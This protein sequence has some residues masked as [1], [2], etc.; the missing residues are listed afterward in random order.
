MQHMISANHGLPHNKTLQK[1]CAIKSPAAPAASGIH[2]EKDVAG[3]PAAAKIDQGQP[4]EQTMMKYKCPD[5][6]VSFAKWGICRQHMISANHGLPH[7]KTLQ[8]RC[9]IK[10]PA[11]QGPAS[12]NFQ[13]RQASNVKTLDMSGAV[14]SVASL[15][16]AQASGI[17]DLLSGNE[18]P[19]PQEDDGL[20]NLS[21]VEV[22]ASS[23]TVRASDCS[24]ADDEDSN[25]VIKSRAAPWTAAD[26]EM[27]GG[28][29]EGGL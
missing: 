23:T 19:F 22:V 21:D 27:S 4:N 3:P 11:A 5:C 9:A 12:G 15:T 29:G 8:N 10:S 20:S 6:P 1:R 16:Y 13:P 17:H 14:P 7:N 18:V 24:R 28:A 26:S 25:L 2:E